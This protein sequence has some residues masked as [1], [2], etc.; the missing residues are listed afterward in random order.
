MEVKYL[1]D[2]HRSQHAE[3]STR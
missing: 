2:S 1:R 3:T